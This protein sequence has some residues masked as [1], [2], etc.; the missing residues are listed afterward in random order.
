M[1][2]GRRASLVLARSS[3]CLAEAKT[4]IPAPSLLAA[5]DSVFAP[6]LDRAFGLRRQSSELSS[7]RD[8]LLP[9]LISG[10]I[11]IPDAEKVLEEVGV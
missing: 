1:S 10:E 3:D 2:L 11:R 9:K 4:L 8:A 7:I 6:L 5:I